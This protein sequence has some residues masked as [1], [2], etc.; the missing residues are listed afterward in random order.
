ML[1]EKG[2]SIS[3]R[4]IFSQISIIFSRYGKNPDKLNLLSHPEYMD[5]YIWKY[6]FH[7]ITDIQ[8]KDSTIVSPSYTQFKTKC[9]EFEDAKK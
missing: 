7:D 2:A 3:I 9:F 8:I 4:F 6:K 5:L 1:L